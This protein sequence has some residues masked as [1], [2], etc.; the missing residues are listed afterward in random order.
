MART[1]YAVTMTDRQTPA[2]GE[3]HYRKK[4]LY[5]EGVDLAAMAKEVGTPFY[6]Y[7]QTGFE[8]QFRSFDSAFEGTPHL[9]C[10]AVKANS[11]LSILSLFR[12]LG[13]GFDIVS[14]G[15]LL[16]AMRV[17]SD[18]R[19]IVFSG[20]GK[21]VDEIDL[22][23]RHEILQFNVESEAELEIIEARAAAAGKV[24]SVAIRVNPDVD[25]K[26]H[27]Y[28]ST[29]RAENKFGVS[30]RSVLPLCRR[31]SRSRNLRITGIGSHIGS[32]IIDAAPF[33]RAA[34]HLA[35]LVRALRASGIELRHLDLGG[36]LGITYGEE[37]PPGPVEYAGAIRRFVEDLGCTLILEPGR[38]MAGNAGVL[39]TRVLLSKSGWTRNFVIVDAAMNDLIRPSLYGAY[40]RIQPV[41]L[42]EGRKWKADVVGPVCESGD[43]LGRDRLLPRV[44]AGELLA[45]MSAGAYGFS[46]S[47]NYNSRPRA[48]EV[49]VRGSEFKIIRKRETFRDVTRG[50]SAYPLK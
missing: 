11:N 30:P 50:E 27:P 21:T 19:K 39:V 1:G 32:Q 29:G 16:R 44:R 45:V 14:G 48:A 37:S 10:Y 8:Q 9:I 31:A 35:R 5:C 42:G 26:T 34:R 18:P 40:H 38:A 23:L 47:S 46:L 36:G 6:V 17:R 41:A 20:V 22:A 33:A 13:A 49:L 15:E 2:A 3:F 7:S 25:A 12:G 43:F 4:S 24:A 28:I